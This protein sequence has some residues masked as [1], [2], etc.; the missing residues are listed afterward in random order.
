MKLFDTFLRGLLL[1]GCAVLLGACAPKPTSLHQAALQPAPATA[2]A[3]RPSQAHLPGLLTLQPD[4]LALTRQRLREGDA[5][6]QP[7]YTALL[8]RADRALITPPRSVVHKTTVPP[9]GDKHDYISM[10]PYWWPNPDTA[11]GLPYVQRD[12]QRNPAVAGEALDSMRLQAMLADT[13]DLALAYT[14]SGDGRYA[15]QAAVVLRTWF[16]APATRMNPNLRF[17]QAVPGVAEGRGIGLIDTRD[18]WWVF[19][20]LA[21]I[22]PARTTQQLSATEQSAL[23]QWFVDYAQWLDTSTLGRHAAAE[24]N[25]HGMFYDVQ[26]AALW[27]HTGQL[28][29]ARQ[30]LADVLT[31]RFAAQIDSQGR[32]PLELAR[33][34]PFHYH[35]FTL[36]A[37][38]RLAHYSRVLA[39]RTGSQPPPADPACLRS[40]Q[41]CTPNLW[42]AEADGRSLGAVVAFIS[43]A[44]TAP[45][46]WPYATALERSPVLPPAVPVLL[47]AQRAL[48]TPATAAA[49]AALQGVALDHIARL[50]WPAP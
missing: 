18:L 39:A 6:V 11:N 38:T 42:R 22:E 24:R 41:P 16:L 10:G 29:R 15:A 36:E 33:T 50:L 26:M 13:R 32:L 45:E 46:A 19:D 3:A 40:P 28:A 5:S 25:N 21:L 20:A 37:M 27:L 2:P 43:A 4:A 34:R 12:G 31:N 17:A 9:S 47:Q 35:T 8:R 7:A 44:V 49:L 14:F 48:P 23:R 1:T 30:L